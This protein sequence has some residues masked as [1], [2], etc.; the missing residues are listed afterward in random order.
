L[1]IDPPPT[2][3][4]P[5]YEPPSLDAVDFA[6]ASGY[7]PPA[8]GSIAIV[9]RGNE[10]QVDLPPYVQRRGDPR[11]AIYRWGVLVV[12]DRGMRLTW[13]HGPQLGPRDPPPIDVPSGGS[14]EPPPTPPSSQVYLIMNDVSVVALPDRTPVEV[15]SVSCS[16]SRDSWC[17]SAQFEL[18]DP[19][20]SALLKPT[21]AGPKLVEISMNGYVWV[22]AVE[23]RDG[24][25]TH[26]SEGGR[27][28]SFSGRSQTALLSDSFISKRSLAVT[29]AR[30]AQQLAAMEITDR[31]LP[32]TIDWAGLDWV[33]P[34]GVWSYQD[35][36]PIDVIS[37]IAAARGAVVQSSPADAA[38]QIRSLYP[39]SP[40]AWTA[41]TADI[42]LPIDWVTSESAQQQNKPLYDAV[43]VIGQQQGVQARVTRQSEAGETFA[44]QV[45]DQLIVTPDVALERGRTILSDRGM[46][47]LVTVEIPLFPPGAVTGG[48]TGLYVPLLIVD[49]QDPEDP[50]QALSV[51][52]EVSARRSGDEDKAMEI[53]QSVSLERHLSDAH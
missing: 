15:V 40:W 49:V 14:S 36:A 6:L 10:G 39:T 25:R 35:M 41:S 43:F 21:S 20:Q 16:A 42:A 11:P 2:G 51:S 45:V 13:G 24:S 31:Q 22:I 5:P 37:Q 3:G 30:S 34:G 9:V 4:A 23:N 47:E 26:P 8:G 29:E 19:S 1:V 27:A 7:T 32:F 53:W 50:Y 28:A 46:Q 44:S 18:A 12:T 17:W 52:V 38:L 33:I 48:A